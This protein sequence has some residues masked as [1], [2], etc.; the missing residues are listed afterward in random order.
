MKIG[1]DARMY[2]PLVG[3][4][5]LG[6]YVE[7]LV[8][9]LQA[10]DHKNRY[11]LFLKKENFDACKITNP[12]FEKRLADIHW[13]TW[14]EQVFLSSL[15]D[16]EK[17][18]LVHFPHWN[19]P[20]NLRTP[21]I[22]TIHDL[23]L[24]EEPKSTKATTL[25][26]VMYAVKYGAYRKVL[27][28]AIRQSAHVISPS[29][30]T[31]DSIQKHF[32]HVQSERIT[33]VHEGVTP[34]S[35]ESAQDAPKNIPKPY[36]LYVGNAFPHKNL[37]FLIQGFEAFSNKHSNIHLV[38]AGRDNPFY[39]RTKEQ[40]AN[41]PASSKIHF[42]KGPTDEQLA[43]LFKHAHAYVFPSRIEG[44]GL[45]P[46]EAMHAGIPVASSNTGSMPEILGDAAEYFSPTS[47]ADLVQALEAVSSNTARRKEL[48]KNGSI[49]IKNYSWETMAY[50]IKRLYESCARN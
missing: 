37:E 1:I 49:Q 29:A 38:F 32:P 40:A 44:F 35:F 36:L 46:L 17:L 27:R 42:V 9:E 12:N 19:V 10:T 33:V 34:L 26:P 50:E 16:S 31:K 7:Q 22:V 41:S 14:K 45:P 15:I 43:R 6:R 2:G 8:D 11:V 23:I 39:Q 30:F 13:Y 18:D 48:I 4:G 24:L 3:G 47:E 21:F 28:N 25:N 5:G 20:L